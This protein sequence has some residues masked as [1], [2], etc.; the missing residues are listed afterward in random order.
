MLPRSLSV[1]SP[2]AILLAGVVGAVVLFATETILAY[3]HV[4]AAEQAFRQETVTYDECVAAVRSSGHSRELFGLAIEATCPLKPSRLVTVS[5]AV[6]DAR[7]S[8]TIALQ[9]GA[10]AIALAALP[11][12][13]SRCTGESADSRASS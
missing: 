8:R 3:R 9:L 2:K 7:R 11:W 5:A 6:Y 4:A 1:T 10:L 13:V 12:I